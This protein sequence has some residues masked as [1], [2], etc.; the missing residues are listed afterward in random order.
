MSLW[1]P[2]CLSMEHL[3]C[4]NAY[5][6]CSTQPSIS[7]M[8]AVTFTWA[9]LQKRKYMQAFINPVYLYIY[10]ANFHCNPPN[11][12]LQSPLHFPHKAEDMYKSRVHVIEGYP[13]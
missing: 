13:L 5:G 6:K 11:Q 7:Q 2:L 10:D 4:I 8:A 12:R 9:H 3:K 1:T